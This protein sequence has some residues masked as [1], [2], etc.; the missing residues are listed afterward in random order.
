MK[1][2]GFTTPSGLPIAI[3]ANQITVI[4]STPSNKKP[5]SIICL[6]N[7]GSYSVI[8]EVSEISERINKATSRVA[9]VG[10]QGEV[11]LI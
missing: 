2:I 11:S 6:S 1:M 8:G 10:K 7:G 9:F 3:D 4:E 5:H